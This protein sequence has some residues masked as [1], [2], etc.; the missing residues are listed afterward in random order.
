MAVARYS[1]H[2][3]CFYVALPQWHVDRTAEVMAVSAL[4]QERP[5]T[6]SPPFG[7]GPCGGR[8][9][10]R[11]AGAIARGASRLNSTP[12]IPTLFLKLTLVR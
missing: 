2:S 9:L 7:S 6:S 12:G 3:A 1:I 5:G 11:V 8:Y 10:W 4:A